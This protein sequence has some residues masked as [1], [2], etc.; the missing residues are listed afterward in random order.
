M[1]Q[2]EKHTRPIKNPALAR[3]LEQMARRLLPLVELDQG[4]THPSFPQTVLS[5]WLL[6]DEQ[7]ESLAHFY[8]QKIPNQYTDLYPCKI[9]WRHNMSLEEKHHEMGKFIGLPGRDL[10]TQLR[11][12]EDNRAEDRRARLAAEDEMRRRKLCFYYL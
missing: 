2:I 1:A 7:L 4:R 3:K 12:D 8:H 9:T 6:T 10:Y 5:F 11:T